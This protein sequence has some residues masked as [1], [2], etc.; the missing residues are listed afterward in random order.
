VILV[1]GATGTVGREVLRRLPADLAVRVMAR[2]PSR[3]ERTAPGMDVVAGD[4]TDLRSLDHALRGVSRAF[5]VTNGVGGDDDV[6]F[7]RAARSAG[8]RHLVKVSA[9]AVEDE[10]ADDLITRWQRTNEELLMGSGMQWT[11]LRP[12]SFMS[13][14]LSW[15]A[16]IN[17]EGIVRGLYGTSANACVDPRDVAAAAVRALSE[18]G[19]DGRI[20]TL[21][22]PEP[23]NAAQQTAQLGRLLGRSLCFEELSRDTA[24]RLLLE[25]HPADIVEALLAGAERQHA[26]AKAG[27]GNTVLHL[28]GRP[29]RSFKAWAEDHLAAFGAVPQA[30]RSGWK[31]Y[32]R[33]PRSA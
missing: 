21:T 12:R 19:H 4:F 14:T 7:L 1:T 27:T 3:V 9:A 30:A 18:D 15:A 11:V 29:A 13:N 28:T 2:D 6:R 31:R 32:S 23:I 16:T 20:Y 17:S 25:R 22:G 24:R 8:V 5:V 26:G 33:S 10:G